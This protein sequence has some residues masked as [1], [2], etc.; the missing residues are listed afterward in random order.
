MICTAIFQ[1]TT[2]Y[3]LAESME[4]LFERWDFCA[5]LSQEDGRRDVSPSEPGDPG[6]RL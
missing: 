2:D 4:F 6:L 5:S 1:P 3:R